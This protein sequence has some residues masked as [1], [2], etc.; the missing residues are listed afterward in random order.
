MRGFRRRAGPL[1]SIQ[2]L[3]QNRPVLGAFQNQSGK[4]KLAS[5]RT[6]NPEVLGP[7]PPPNIAIVV[8]TAAPRAP[9]SGPQ[10][11]TQTSPTLLQ[12]RI[13][14]AYPFF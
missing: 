6:V 13:K 14:V 11:R 1:M 7:Y 12:I 10:P 9:G 5:A 3:L 2:S 8:S 4:E